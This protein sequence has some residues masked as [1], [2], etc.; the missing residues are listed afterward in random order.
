MALWEFGASAR[1]YRVKD[2]TE[3]MS[4]LESRSLTKA[5]GNVINP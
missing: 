2:A 4:A 3:V 5:A 1:R